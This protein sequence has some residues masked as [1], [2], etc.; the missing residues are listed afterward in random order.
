MQHLIPV[1]DFQTCSHIGPISADSLP[2]NSPLP[3]ACHLTDFQK[4]NMH[5]GKCDFPASSEKKPQ[6][7]TQSDSIK[8]KLF[9][10]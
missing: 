1:N 4:N 9:S 3:V 10:T 2:F 8:A 7:N 6:L 5:A